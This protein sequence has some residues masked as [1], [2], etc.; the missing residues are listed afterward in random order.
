MNVL[1]NEPFIFGFR[2]ANEG[3]SLTLMVTVSE[4]QLV[5]WGVGERLW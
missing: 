1:S 4:P 5:R 2:A 3:L